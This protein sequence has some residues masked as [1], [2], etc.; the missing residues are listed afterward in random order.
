MVP[1]DHIRDPDAILRASFA[2]IEAEAGLARLPAEIVPVARRVIHACGMTDVAGDLAFSSGATQAGQR[3]LA[4]GAPILCEARMVAAGIAR[5][6]LPAGN[7]ILVAVAEPGC[8]ERAATEATTRSAAGMALLAYRLEGAVVIVGNA[9]TALFRLLELIAAGSG[10][11]A[12]VLG[13]PVGF[14]GAAES[15]AA[16]AD[17]PWGVPFIALHGRRGGSAMAAAALNALILESA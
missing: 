2:A 11:P 8:A 9:P 1:L 12:L 17:N 6:R 7:D 4:A 13:F 10:R 14:V 16:L 3:A 15:K 5:D